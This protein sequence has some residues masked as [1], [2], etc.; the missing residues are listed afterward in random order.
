MS[1]EFEQ[2]E[3]EKQNHLFTSG[4]HVCSSQRQGR[5]EGK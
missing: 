2:P 1:E 5:G 4:A 3:D